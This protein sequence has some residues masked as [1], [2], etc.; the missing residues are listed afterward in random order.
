MSTSGKCFAILIIL[1]AA[2]WMLALRPS[3][4]LFAK[5]LMSSTSQQTIEEPQ[6]EIHDIQGCIGGKRTSGDAIVMMIQKNHSTYSGE[7][8]V[9][10]GGPLIT[11]KEAYPQVSKADIL[12]WHEGDF[13]W[14]DVPIN[15]L[16][17]MNVRLCNLKHAEGA[18][19]PPPNAQ[20]PPKS[21][22]MPWSVGYRNMIRFYAVTVW[23]VLADMGYEY[24]MRLDDDSNFMSPIQYNLFDALRSQDA[25]YGYRMDVR[26][27]G[28]TDFGPDEFSGW[29]DSYV[30]KTQTNPRHGPLT[31]S[32]CKKMGRFGFYN[33]FFLT[34]IDWWRR[35]EVVHFEKAF[36]ESNY[37]Y[38][39]RY[40]DLL[41]HTA[42]IKLFAE[43]REVLKYVDWSYAHVTVNHGEWVYGGVSFGT[44]DPRRKKS[45]KIKHFQKWMMDRW[46]LTLDQVGVLSFDCNVT[47][48][49]CG[50]SS[51][52][53]TGEHGIEL[54]MGL[55]G[56]GPWWQAPA[57]VQ[58]LPK[59]QWHMF[60]N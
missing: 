42:A 38:S 32:Y 45:K 54:Q 35:P 37:I 2:N 31:E 9:D 24:V 18:W 51:C 59:E 46:G 12:L 53:K 60:E 56:T 27:C 58:C 26:E 22:E 34:R 44:E 39:K 48:H 55:Q 47:N 19:G 13:T 10:I 30:N 25:V 11:L 28:S 33:N 49:L 50:V 41:F 23:D 57:L 29:V 7:H 43:P 17:G 6:Q 20:V 5:T 1:F 52:A 40:G 16:D 14:D 15:K 4:D 8:S 3:L 36:D 21:P